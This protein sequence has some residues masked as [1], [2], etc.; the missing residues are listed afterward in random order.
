MQNSFEIGT[1]IEVNHMGLGV[2][3]QGKVSRDR[4]GTCDVIFETDGTESAVDK[5]YIR[6]LRKDTH[7][8]N[9]ID[10]RTTTNQKN[11]PKLESQSS[12]ISKYKQSS[13]I[14]ILLF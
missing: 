14:I 2:W 3:Y 6:L 9:V 8:N 4:E 13:T 10:D 11:I 1:K 5:K 12:Q 7:S